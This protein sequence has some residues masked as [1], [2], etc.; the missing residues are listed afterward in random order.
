MQHRRSFGTG[1]V[2]EAT[3]KLR[4]TIRL[5]LEERLELEKLIRAGKT[6]FRKHRRARM[7]L[8]RSQGVSIRQIARRLRTNRT[9]VNRWVNRFR[10]RRLDGLQDLPRTGRPNRIGTLERTQIVAMA[11]QSP[12]K[13][14]LVR[15]LWSHRA[16]SEAAMEAGYSQQI[17]GDT[18]RRI[19]K[20]AEI[21]PHRVKMWCHSKDPRFQEKLRDIVGLYLGRQGQ[22]P[23]LCVD[24]KSGMQALSRQRGLIGPKPARAL[25]LEFEYRRNGTCCL[26]ACFDVHTGQVVG[27]CT[28]RRRRADF[29]SFLDLVAERYPQK[30]I[31]VVLDNLVTHCDTSAGDFISQWNRGQQNRFCFHYTP[32]HGSWLNQ[33]ELWFSILSRR[34][35]RHGSFSSLQDLTR[36]LEA[37]I[38]S[39]N[40]K[41]AHPFRWT[42][43][44]LPLVA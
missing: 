8:W 18:V 43:D 17:S 30:R 25:R 2:S 37:F 32:T 44:G 31:H 6:E 36:Q 27:R 24:E 33:I 20:R 10:Q 12:A 23:V 41:E 16:L 11:C 22:E 35:L 19:L 40:S 38:E 15:N 7:I 1:D 4:L 34:V 13:Y 21:K 29:L 5:N 9:T 14:G 28:K 3:A 42:C 26:F 39:W